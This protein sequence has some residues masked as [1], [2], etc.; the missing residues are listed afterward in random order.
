MSNVSVKIVKDAN[1]YEVRVNGF[2]F[3]SGIFDEM[4]ENEQTII[5]DDNVFNKFLN[6][7]KVEINII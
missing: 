3:S 7:E 4:Y 2:V 5:L 6:G 1:Y